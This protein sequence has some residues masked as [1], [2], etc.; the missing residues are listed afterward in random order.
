LM[1]SQDDSHLDTP[2][3]HSDIASPST[4]ERLAEELRSDSMSPSMRSHASPVS[5]RFAQLRTNLKIETSND[6]MALSNSKSSK[7]AGIQQFVKWFRS[8]TQSKN[9]NTEVVAE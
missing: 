3:A 2:M 8:R 7:P 1:G 5:S 6:A 4:H 9:T